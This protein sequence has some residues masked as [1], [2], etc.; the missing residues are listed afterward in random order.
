[1]FAKF[2]IKI[3]YPPPYERNIW[4][5]EKTNAD[6]IRRSITLFSYYN[7][8]PNI[9]VKQV[10]LFKNILSNFIPHET[11]ACDDRDPL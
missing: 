8:F 1:M 7:R 6:L 2:D 10:Y 5:Y 4:H 11:V 3:C 9:D